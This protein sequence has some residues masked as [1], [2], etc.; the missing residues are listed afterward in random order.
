M[1]LVVVTAVPCWAITAGQLSDF[2]DGTAQGWGFGFGPVPVA[3][4]SGP[5]GAGDFA[6]EMSNAD[7]GGGRLLVIADPNRSGPEAIDWMGNWT[8]AGIT[9]V[10]MDVKNSSDFDLFL[11]LGIAG[12]EGGPFNGGSGDT[13][14]TDAIIVPDDDLWHTIMFDVLPTDFISVGGE[15]TPAGA[16]ADIKHL[17]VLHNPLESFLGTFD[18]GIFLLDNIRAIGAT[19]GSLDGDYNDN[20]VVDA[21]D[22][23]VWRD[24]L[25][26]TGADL[27]ADGSG[28][29][30]MP[31]GA[32]DQL[33]YNFW[34]ANFGNMSP[35]GG[36]HQHGLSSSV[37][38]VPEATSMALGVLGLG[39]FVLVLRRR[40]LAN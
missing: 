35:S 20:G 12:P 14:V 16:L 26:A 10:Q 25:G 5:A 21:A 29:G 19:T 9:Q 1:L 39:T 31:D 18:T 13:H 36:G 23:T 17:R 30:G 34:K 38:S 27:P 28:A 8:A 22:Y 3:P 7:T 4:D 24:M 33:D 15:G 6:L 11:R 2:Q 40:E 32:V 37:A